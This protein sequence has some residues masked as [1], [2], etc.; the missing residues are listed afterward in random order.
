MFESVL[1]FIEKMLPTFTGAMLAFVSNYFLQ[2]RQRRI[3][4]VFEC[5][6][7]IR[8]NIQNILDIYFEFV[9]DGI[10][11]AKINSLMLSVANL[12]QETENL[13]QFT[14]IFEF[15]KK[16]KE[17]SEFIAHIT[18][19]VE[20]LKKVR[21]VREFQHFILPRSIAKIQEIQKTLVDVMQDNYKK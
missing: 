18:S 13:R 20:K 19:D 16:E 1:S 3:N 21:D 5:V 9:N 8:K 10:Q 7:E 6:S 14:S 17:F 4:Y 15:V 12:Q 11:G 2:K